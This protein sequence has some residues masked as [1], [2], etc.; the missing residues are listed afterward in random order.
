MLNW[1]DYLNDHQNEAAKSDNSIIRGPAGCG[2]TVTLL[3]RI[4]YLIEELDIS[5]EKILVLLPDLFAVKLLK[6]ELVL[7]IGEKLEKLTIDSV[8]HFAYELLKS[9]NKDFSLVNMEYIFENIAGLGEKNIKKTDINIFRKYYNT[10]TGYSDEGIL[11]KI[12]IFEELLEKMNIET[13]ETIVKKVLK[14]TE[15]FS[16]EFSIYEYVLFDR[17]EQISMA[18]YKLFKNISIGKNIWITKTSGYCIPEEENIELSKGKVP[19]SNIIGKESVKCTDG[20]GNVCNCLID[21]V[22][23]KPYSGILVNIKTSKGKKISATPNHIMFARYDK[24]SSGYQIGI[25]ENRDGAWLSILEDDFS[26]KSKKQKNKLPVKIWVL[27]TFD[28]YSKAISFLSYISC[29]YSIPLYKFANIIS[30]PDALELNKRLSGRES[31][32]K[33]K[34]DFFISS[35]FPHFT[36]DESGDKT[37]KIIY[38]GGEK[39]GEKHFHVLRIYNGKEKLI[40]GLSGL[41]NENWFVQT[42]KKDFEEVLEF[43]KSISSVEGIP[44]N[45]YIQ[46]TEKEIFQ[47]FPASHIQPGMY[48]PILDGNSIKEDKVISVEWRDYIGK[49]ADVSVPECRN[50]IVNGVLVHNSSPFRFGKGIDIEEVIKKDFPKLKNIEFDRNYRSCSEIVD[51]INELSDFKQESAV[52]DSAG[53]L[54]GIEVFKCRDE[55]DE[56]INIIDRIQSIIF[57]HGKS[58]AD[59][60][61]F[62]RLSKQVEVFKEQFSKRGIPFRVISEDN[63]FKLDEI[64]DFLAYIYIALNSK[65]DSSIKRIINIPRRGIGNRTIELIDNYRKE[66]NVNF[67]KALGKVYN[68]PDFPQRFVKQVKGFK[69]LIDDFI[70]K[71][72]DMEMKEFMEY[73]L[74]ESKI[75]T[76]FSKMNTNKALEC[77]AN[78]KS[79]PKRIMEEI[80]SFNVNNLRDC[81]AYIALRN[82]FEDYR[83]ENTITLSDYSLAGYLEFPVVFMSGVEEGLVPYFKNKNINEEKTLFI[84]AL[85]RTSDKVFFSFS[86]HRRLNNEKCFGKPSVFIEKCKAIDEDVSVQTAEMRESSIRKEKRKL[87]KSLQSKKLQVGNRVAHRMWGQGSIKSLSGAGDDLTAVVEFDNVGE[88]KLILKYAPLQKL[89]D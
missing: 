81:M 37:L 12:Y 40:R 64:G 44:V 83:E 30:S 2:K 11:K 52:K 32:R 89:S 20:F 27:K 62:Y 70:K 48:I 47:F 5:P 68:E 13:P 15:N 19:L 84:R 17:I 85:S 16:K 82:P 56:V 57:K 69:E 76:E 7:Y 50:F 43:S 78:I 61:I 88:R 45:Q 53:E 38:F 29:R 22:E 42:E 79:F 67:F 3:F 46:A 34:R 9:K 24:G 60:A 1:F 65:D 21:R 36:I 58:Y 74:E 18:E 33:L 51:A 55:H 23:Y 86:E 72:H 14:N 35:D 73:I 49:T 26:I 77:I 80:V 28:K 10:P 87:K 25:V 6:E 54:K 31:S 75:T 59:F 41:R 8:G 63:F 4:V 66:N 39:G 71:S